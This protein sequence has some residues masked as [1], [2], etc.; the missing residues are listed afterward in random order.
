MTN[1]SL[2]IDIKGEAAD[3]TLLQEIQVLE[4]IAAAVSH[5]QR[6]SHLLSP[7]VVTW[8]IRRMR[9]GDQPE[10]PVNDFPVQVTQLLQ[11]QASRLQSQRA[12]MDHQARVIETAGVR[13]GRYD[14]M[15]DLAAHFQT[16]A[17]RMSKQLGIAYS[18]VANETSI[19]AEVKRRL[20]TILTGDP[21]KTTNTTATSRDRVNHGVAQS[22]NS[23][24]PPSK[25]VVE[26]IAAKLEIA[27]KRAACSH[28]RTESFDD[29][30]MYRCLSCGATG[31]TG[32]GKAPT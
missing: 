14:E 28:Q 27:A 21:Q 6:L 1:V 8:A 5:T 13:A 20:G 29:G 9:D 23:W 7:T 19:P 12:V 17:I 18:I 2:H 4:H 22:I 30:A 32:S 16:E 26:E 10:P 24:E 3:L 11:H 15:M 25:S 31:I